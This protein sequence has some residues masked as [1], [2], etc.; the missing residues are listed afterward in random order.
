M[1]QLGQAF[2]HVSLLGTE[3]EATRLRELKAE[4]HRQKQQRLASAG[5]NF[6][7]SST[8]R[9]RRK[10]YRMQLRVGSSSPH[11]LQLSCPS[12]DCVSKTA[13]CYMEA[14]QHSLASSVPWPYIP[15][16]SGCNTLNFSLLAGRLRG[17]DANGSGAIGVEAAMDAAAAGAEGA[18]TAAEGGERWKHRP[19]LLQTKTQGSV[20]LGNS[21]ACRVVAGVVDEAT[22]GMNAGERSR[23]CAMASLLKTL[24]CTFAVEP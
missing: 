7:Q 9:N 10:L 4:Y 15:Q 5:G 19:T 24:E 17:L 18:G 8:C 6:G 1:A 22:G 20:A 16:L 21:A 23:L 11:L 13:T 14:A 2:L 12:L 3:A